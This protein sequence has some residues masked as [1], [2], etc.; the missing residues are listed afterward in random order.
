MILGYSV[1]GRRYSAIQVVCLS[2]TS[3]T[4]SKQ[5]ILLCTIQ[6]SVLVVSFGAILATLSK[7]SVA[8][9]TADPV[10]TQRYA[11]G[12][13]MIVTSLLLTGILGVLQ[14]QTYKKYGPCW[15]EGVFYT[16][17]IGIGF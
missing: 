11:L 15:K 3:L 6:I 1:L 13:A 16:V 17:N 4:S 7:S 2:D 10:D 5:L 9:S 12:I 14:E 8:S